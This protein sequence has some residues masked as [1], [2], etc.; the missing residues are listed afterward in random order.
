MQRTSAY[1]ALASAILSPSWLAAQEATNTPSSS[2]PAGLEE[3]VITA[4]K[5][6]ERLQDVPV[7][8]AVV[9]SDQLANSNISDVSDLNKLVPS[10]NING[11]INGRAPMGMRGI[12]SV[13]NESAVGVP[14]G[15]AIMVDGVPIPSDSFAGNNIED[16]RNVEVLK[17]PQATLGGRTAAAGVINYRT[18][19][20]TDYLTGGAS[21]TATTDSE[22]RFNGHISGPI[23]NGLDYSLSAYAAQRYFP[24]TNTFYDQKTGQK[25]WGLRGK[26]LW[27]ITD[28]ISA[29]LTYHHATSKVDEFNF[30]YLYATPGADLLFS[31]GPLSQSLLLP[32]IH[33]SYDNLY[34]DSPVQGAGHR[35]DD[36]DGQIDLTF[37]LGGGYTLTSTTAYQHEDQSQTQDLFD[38]AVYFFDT[39]VTGAP[40]TSDPHIFNDQQYQTERVTQ[41]SEEIK[42]VSPADQPVSF[43]AGLFY[44]NTTVDSHYLRTLPPAAEDVYVK[45]TTSTYDIYGRATWKFAPSTSLVAGLRYNYDVLKYSYNELIYAL[46]STAVFGPYYST[47]NS[48]YCSAGG[49][50]PA[51]ATN[52]SQSTCNSQAV[53]GDISLQQQ[54][55][56]DVMA[57]F[58]YARGY[59]PEVYNT[60][61]TLTSA[62]PLEPVGQERINH[63]ELGLKGTYLDRRLIANVA[64]FDTIYNHY[65][66]QQ[67]S[68]IPG[69]IN[70]I[71]DLQAAGKAETRGFELDSTWRATNTTTFGV[72]AAYVDAVFKDYPGA[73]C[74]PDIVVGVTPS[75]C[76]VNSDGTVTQDMSGKPMPNAPK[77]KLN[78]DAQQRIP[79]GG[80]P[81]EGVLGANWSYRTKA[82]MLPDNNPE[83]IMP[84]FGILNLSAGITGTSGKWSIVAFCNNVFNRV[85]YEDIEDFWSSPWSGANMVI[86]QPARDAQRYGGVRLSASF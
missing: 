74:E 53:V 17:G 58:T 51:T 76:T 25:N 85:Y 69:A 9:S 44:S 65:Q 84:A 18:Y 83:G 11:T 39:L 38:T 3:I 57:Y 54:I 23:A 40:V 33:P 47:S 45:P 5:R 24:I 10:L 48:H 81:F 43:V 35:H 62:A 28:D 77:W 61:A 4:Q 13:S 80:L 72:S 31:P 20:P 49:T 64:L 2:E 67:F 68:V 75:N 73:A 52:Y 42:L 70:P 66:I 36:N 27:N 22:Y 15:V 7:S 30:V 41:T 55:M 71:L 79:L 60:A 86:G 14:S 59:S 16:I 63:F 1:L 8:A 34:R 82:Q 78:L 50:A 6:T 12:S 21:A 29:K 32:G 56:P 37:N 26:L 46:S 19:D